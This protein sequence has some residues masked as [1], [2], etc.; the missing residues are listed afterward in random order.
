MSGTQSV[1]DQMTAGIMARKDEAATRLT[2][3]GQERIANAPSDVAGGAVPPP[4]AALPDEE[5]Q[6]ILAAIVEARQELARAE[7]SL[8]TARRTLGEVE[9]N[10]NRANGY[11][12]EAD[13][14]ARR[15]R[16]AAPEKPFAEHYAELQARAQSAV[17]GSPADEPSPQPVEQDAPTVGWA[18]PEHGSAS[19]T[20]LTSRKGRTYRSCTAC[21]EFE[22]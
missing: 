10:I 8:E 7:K 5:R 1:L 14:D 17:F 13:W 22:K 4:T 16:T 9:R 2:P 11:M 3:V 6:S 18:C 15:A 21:Q 19:L 12:L 20:T